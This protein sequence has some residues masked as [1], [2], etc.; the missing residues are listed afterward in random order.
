VNPLAAARLS[1][2]MGQYL[3]L[4]ILV[5]AVTF[6]WYLRRPDIS[7]SEARRLVKEERARLID[8]RSRGE[9]ASG[10][11]EGARNIPVGEI[12]RRSG[13]LGPSE[14]PIVLYCASGSRSAMAARTLRGAGFSRV[15]NLGPMTNW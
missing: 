9:Y 6:L 5:L 4:G 15:Y 14:R 1:P 13:E 10:H 7:S 2:A 8:V 3:L 11:L 12:G